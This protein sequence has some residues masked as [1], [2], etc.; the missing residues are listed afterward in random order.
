MCHDVTVVVKSNLS[1]SHCREFTGRCTTT[2]LR[3]TTRSRSGTATSS[4]TLSPSTRAGCTAPCSGPASPACCRPITWSVATRGARTE[5]DRRRTWSN[6][7]SQIQPRCSEVSSQWCSLHFTL[8][9]QVR[10]FFFMWK[11]NT[12]KVTHTHTLNF[13]CYRIF[14]DIC[15]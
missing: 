2:Q 10:F 4:S 1:L 8:R 11:T 14:R 12:D 7:K 6:V 13:R 3:T 5:A 15:M 9:P